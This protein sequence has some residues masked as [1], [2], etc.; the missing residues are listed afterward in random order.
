MAWYVKRDVL[1]ATMARIISVETQRLLAK[2]IKQKI[3]GPGSYRN[4]IPLFLEAGGAGGP[5][6]AHSECILYIVY[7]VYILQLKYYVTVRV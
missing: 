4:W 2:T 1:V 3:R 5:T 7:V 6:Q